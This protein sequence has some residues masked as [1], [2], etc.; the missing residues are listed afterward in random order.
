M[1]RVVYHTYGQVNELAGI[2]RDFSDAGSSWE[3]LELLT[4]ET[5]QAGWPAAAIDAKGAVQVRYIADLVAASAT[6]TARL[7]WR[8]TLTA[9]S[10]SPIRRFR[11]LQTVCALT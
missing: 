5:S 10:W 8:S 6:A 2:S 7:I 11:A 1:V 4:P 9:L 3:S